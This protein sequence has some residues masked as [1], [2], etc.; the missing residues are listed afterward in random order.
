MC[1]MSAASETWYRGGEGQTDMGGQ[2]M[3]RFIGQE[4]NFV[5]DA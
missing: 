4:E 1:L 2:G 5:S 3:E